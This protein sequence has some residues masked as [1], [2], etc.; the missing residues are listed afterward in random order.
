MMKSIKTIMLAALLLLVAMVATTQSRR[1]E[2]QISQFEQNQLDLGARMNP[3][4]DRNGDACARIKFHVRDTS[5][6]VTSNMGVLKRETE[7]GVISVW[8]PQ[9]TKRLTIRHEGVLPLVY[10]IPMAIVTKTGWTITKSAD[11]LTVNPMSGNNTE[12]VRV[13]AG[14]NPTSEPRYATLT[15]KG[16]KAPEKYVK[17]TQNAGTVVPEVKTLT[18]DVSSLTF[19]AKGEVMTIKIA[20]NTTWSITGKPEWC[21]LSESSGSG[22]R[23]ITVTAN[24]NTKTED[25]SGQIVIEGD[26]VSKVVIDVTQKAK[27]L[28]EP[29]PD[30]N[31][32]PA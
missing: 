19:E 1:Q 12:T 8:V 2:I 10:N 30:D 18:A 6:V 17:V 23:D 5:F 16:G 26:G 25:R 21:L 28:Q 9:G 32:P 14:K 15:V 4:L 13:S 20:S 27:E 7:L 3:V 11:W 22:S 29:G 31:T 24:E